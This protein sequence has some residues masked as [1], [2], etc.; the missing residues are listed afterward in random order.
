MRMGGVKGLRKPYWVC[1][2]R[3]F[4]I[5]YKNEIELDDKFCNF[6]IIDWGNLLRMR[7]VNM[8]YFA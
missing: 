6:L 3:Y 4:I 8:V 7:T 5:D 1:F 2:D